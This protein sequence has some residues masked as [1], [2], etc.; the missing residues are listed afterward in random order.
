MRRPLAP[1]TRSAPEVSLDRLQAA[2]E[3]REHIGNTQ[4]LRVGLSMGACLWFAFA[5]AD[6]YIAGVAYDAPI[7]PIWAARVAITPFMGLF[8]WRMYR[9]VAPSPRALAIMDAALFSATSASLGWMCL[10]LGGLTSPYTDALILILLCRG[11]FVVQPWRAALLANFIISLSHFAVLVVGCMVMAS[12]PISRAD[13]SVF[14]LHVAYVATGAALI[15][16]SSHTAWTL[17]R[18]AFAQ[19]RIADY[20]LLYPLAQ[21]GQADVWHAHHRGTRRDV[22]LKILTGPTN[23]KKTIRFMREFEFLSQLEHPN[24]VT[25]LDYGISDEQIWYYAMELL[26]GSTLAEEVQRNGPMEVH[27]AVGLFIDVCSALSASHANGV[28]HRD[29]KPENIFVVPHPS[30]EQAKLLDYGISRLLV[31]TPP[32]QL[33]D[34][35]RILGTPAFM[36]PELVMGG[37]PDSLSDVYSTSASFWF[38]ITGRLPFDGGSV[39]ST[40]KA[41]IDGD[42]EHLTTGLAGPV[43]RRVDA[44][45]RA[46]LSVDRSKRPIDPDALSRALQRLCDETDTAELP[47]RSSQTTAESTMVPWQSVHPLSLSFERSE[48]GI[49]LLA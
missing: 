17:R 30:G 19:R 11:A 9:K 48:D 8:V 1:P 44:V 47:A 21:G 36:P 40:L 37:Q 29:V 31:D 4:R 35:D 13:W 2:L 16:L 49:D 7:G 22:A 25:V 26:T 32:V 42:R 3:T 33:T 39:E 38:A 23:E 24:I 14:G 5:I 27:R 12:E 15:V 43:G 46:C 6:W 41:Q 18:R 45:L 34:P 20:D 10:S 28:V